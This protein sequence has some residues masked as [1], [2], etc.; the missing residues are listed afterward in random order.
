MKTFI[1]HRLS[2]ETIYATEV[3]YDDPDSLRTAIQSAYLSDANLRDANLGGA[4]LRGAKLAGA[5]LSGADLAH[6]NFLDAN[7][8]YANL[9]LIR[10]DFRLV[11][12]A[13]PNEVSGLLAALRTGASTDPSTKAHARVSSAPSRGSEGVV[14]TRWPSYRQIALG[15]PRGGSAR[16][17]L[18]SRR[19]TTRSPKSPRTGSS[20]GRSAVAEDPEAYGAL[21]AKEIDWRKIKEILDRLNWIYNDAQFKAPEAKASS[22][23]MLVAGVMEIA[24]EI[25][26]GPTKEE[27]DLVV[28]TLSHLDVR[29]I[30]WL[31]GYK[32]EHIDSFLKKLGVG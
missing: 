2:E 4:Y 10:D 16:S 8:A 25:G 28:A 11:L 3:E 20:S 23:N 7:L 18:A 1:K 22:C 30:L 26:Y 6:A 21:T 13:A 31:C 5:N 27:R 19:R 32:R 15:R 12:D 14:T 17:G 9:R 29:E 24:D